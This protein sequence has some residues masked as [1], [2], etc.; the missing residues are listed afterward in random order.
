M[1]R[2]LAARY[3]NPHEPQEDLIQVAAM[4]LL[5]AADRFDPDRGVPFASFAI[6][7]IL[8]EIKRHF[9]STGWSVHVPRGAQELAQ[10]V[11][12]ATRDISGRIGRAPRVVE[13]AEFLEIGVEDVVIG[14]DAATAHY[15]AS[16]DVP[17]PGGEGD[18]L[19]TLGDGLGHDEEGFGLVEAKLS[20]A[21]TMRRLPHL[22][23]TALR[24]RIEHDLKQSEIAERMGCSQMQVSRLLRRAATRMRALTDP[25]V[26]GPPV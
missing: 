22:E 11:D 7:T 6:P 13:I 8:G 20:V 24:L 1:A 3:N 5:A 16:L 21:M 4:G 10:R 17:A 15:A 23:R 12:R 14:L 26:A 18:D 2:R 25:H 19:P 9:R